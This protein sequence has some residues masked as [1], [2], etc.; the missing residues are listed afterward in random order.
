MEDKLSLIETA[1]QRLQKEGGKDNYCIFTAN[2]KK[3]YYIQF[4]LQRDKVTCR[5][6]AVSNR[7]LAA[8]FALSEV[9]LAQLPGLGWQR[10]SSDQDGSPNF[11]QDW[12]IGRDEARLA[13]ARLV[14]RTLEEVY[15]LLPDQ[16]LVVNLALE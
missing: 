10:P 7:F 6:E 8:E 16:P 13:L 14:L 4:T 15:G 3:N 5:G 11:Y 12:Q 2:I 1:L 9:Q